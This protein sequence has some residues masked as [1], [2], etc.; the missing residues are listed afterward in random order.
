MSGAYDAAWRRVRLVVLERDDHR[1]R[2]CGDEAT[3]VDH[4]QAL[5]DGG[6]R[7]D[8]DN[9]AASCGPCNYRRGARITNRRR[10]ARGRL[11]SGSGWSA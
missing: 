11:R 5:A 3:T 2:W 1:C 10:R 7:L 4:L 9:L 8:L 6:D